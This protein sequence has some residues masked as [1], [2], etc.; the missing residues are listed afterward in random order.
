MDR[1]EIVQRFLRKGVLLQPAALDMLQGMNLE[2]TDML[3]ADLVARGILVAG[4]DDIKQPDVAQTGVPLPT[5]EILTV[6]GSQRADSRVDYLR[7]FQNRFDRLASII[8]RKESFSES[9]SVLEVK[10]GPPGVC[11]TI[12]MVFDKSVTRGGSPVIMLEDG[13]GRLTAIV[14]KDSNV[15]ETARGLV[16]DEVVG[17]LGSYDADRKIY[18]ADAIEFPDVD[19]QSTPL[20]PERV[21]A[22]FISDLHFG[23]PDFMRE[24]F[25]DFVSWMN[26]RHGGGKER[27]LSRLTRYLV[28]AGDL[29]SGDDGLLEKYN[30][31]ASVLAGLPQELAVVAIPGE[32]DTSGILEPQT[33]FLE[34][35]RNAFS[36]L[37]NFHSAPNPCMLAL[38][39]VPVLLYHGR[40]L[41]DWGSE[42]GGGTKCDLMKQML[43][44]RHIAPTYGSAVPM[45]PSGQDPF[46][47]GEV[48]RVFHVGHG[49]RSCMSRYKGIVLL[50]TASWVATDL[51]Q[52]AGRVFV[53]DLSTLDVEELNFART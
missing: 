11:S 53:V 26:G 19:E 35:A 4:E 7:H 46:I 44:R 6:P 16:L 34:E 47:I 51:P 43:V 31:L 1:R 37:P 33:G 27:E 52:G 36:R 8:K 39:S 38:S 5:V 22:A 23:S 17:L 14:P 24:E 21:C 42:L 18:A 45:I 28:I 41:E 20:A 48:P 12:G 2:S 49:H 3:I 30:G 13:T 50:S 25:D 9:K 40:S 15:A 32:T 10:S 29:V